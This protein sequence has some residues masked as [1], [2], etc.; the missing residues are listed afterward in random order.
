MS[1]V[2][3]HTPRSDRSEELATALGPDFEAQLRRIW[4][5][6][7][8]VQEVEDELRQLR[9]SLEQ[10]RRELEEMRERTIGLI[11]SRLDES[12]R[13]VFRR[14]RE[15]LPATLAEFD[16]ELERVLIGY[17][18]AKGTPYERS[19]K[20]GRRTITIPASS[21]LPGHLSSGLSVAFGAAHDL[22]EVESLHV[23][24]PL[25]QEAVAEARASGSGG[26]CAESA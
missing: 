11:E 19:E 9:D 14:I 2:V 20:Q 10:R 22:E 13:Q 26:R 16:E 23:A 21:E 17:L 3:L 15:E 6:A 4:E 24:H 1:D 7:R 5:R 8:S 12:V 18:D 25:I